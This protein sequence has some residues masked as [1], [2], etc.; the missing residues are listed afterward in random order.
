MSLRELEIRML[1]A[2]FIRGPSISKVVHDDLSYAHARK[3]LEVSRLAI[4]FLN[5]RIF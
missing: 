5:V 2:Q 1:A 4:G 3:A